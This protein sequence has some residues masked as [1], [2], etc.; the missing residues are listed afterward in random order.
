MRHL[1]FRVRVALWLAP[2]A[3]FLMLAGCLSMHGGPTSP[4]SATATEEYVDPESLNRM[5]AQL[6]EGD[7]VNPGGP[8]YN[9]LVLS[10]GGPYGAFTAGTL[11]GWSETGTRPK[12]D[13]VTG[14]STGALVSVFAFLGP[15]WDDKLAKVLSDLNADKV[16][17]MRR[18]LSMLRRS[19]FA[20][21]E[22]LQRLIEDTVDVELMRA[23]AQAHAEG[24][25]LYVGTTNLESRR[26]AVW[27]LGTIASRGDA[28]ALKLLQTIL[29]ASCSIPGFFEPVPI[30][31]Q[32][33]GQS[34]TEL[35]VDGG[36][37]A[38]MFLRLP[39][40]AQSLR[41][42][43][44][45]AGSNLYIIVAGKIYADPA[46]V[47]PGFITIAG[48][49]IS[50]LLYAEARGDLYRLFTGSLVSGIKY[51]LV[52][53]PQD[54]AIG[55]NSTLFGATE[56]KQ[57]YEEGVR[58]GRSPNPW[59]SLP[60]GAETSERTNPQSSVRQAVPAITSVSA[61]KP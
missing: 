35:H 47:R 3:G 14:V 16:Y 60:P 8:H 45:L 30:E 23:V 61:N 48:S 18:P 1:R 29:L 36:A 32:N 53:V 21:S 40:G 44:P 24:R 37:S 42:R 33:N 22:P 57:L 46:P 10:T 2:V 26:L 50:S 15:E 43:R 28:E 11:V 12:F 59:R 19:S 55:P 34:H 13:C 54:F 56:I 49:S 38:A 25:R 58:I 17:R 27:D 9:V 7:Q 31:V 52:A 39:D 41:G 4:D 20:S 6:A 5:V 51:H